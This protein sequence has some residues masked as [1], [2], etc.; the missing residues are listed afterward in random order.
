M[1]AMIT[2]LLTLTDD[3]VFGFLD[4]DGV[5]HP[6]FPL[7][8]LSDEENAHFSSLPRFEAV[9]R[10]C[11]NL[12]LVISSSWRNKY[13]LEELRSFFSPDIAQ[14]IIGTTP[15]IGAG[16]GDGGRQVEVEAW[17][18][19]HGFTD[20]PWIGIDDYAFLYSPGAVVVQCNDQFAERETALLLRALE[21]PIEYEA[22]H[23]VRGSTG[24]KKIIV[25]GNR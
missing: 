25:P 24:E 23:P 1:A 22:A 15:A 9:V 18:E 20:R 3:T 21:D 12:M 13:S 11:P 7:P 4:F 19:Q 6:F 14:R 8:D 5:L 17:L 16:N 10:Q 2:N